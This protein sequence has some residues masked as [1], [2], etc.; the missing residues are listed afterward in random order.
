MTP[1][2]LLFLEP[3]AL[4]PDY[5][6]LASGMGGYHVVVRDRVEDEEAHFGFIGPLDLLPAPAGTPAF[7]RL[8]G[9][10]SKALADEVLEA[11]EEGR[12]EDLDLIEGAFAGRGPT[13]VRP[14]VP[15]SQ[16]LAGGPAIPASLM[17]RDAWPAPFDL[18][19]AVA[20]V[21]AEELDKRLPAS[22][23]PCHPAPSPRGRF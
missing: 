11:R 3:Q 2:Y 15:S 7:V 1:R 5:P 6:G 22:T 21:Q 16:A 14:T 13:L 17:A 19:A 8:V 9:W 4:P 20:R 18:E 12:H 10:V 23:T